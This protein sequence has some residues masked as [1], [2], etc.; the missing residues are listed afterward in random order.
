[1]NW[2]ITDDAN[3]KRGDW[4]YETWGDVLNSVS[5]F[6]IF[7]FFPN[8]GYSFVKIYAA[9]VDI[10]YQ[11]LKNGISYFGKMQAFFNSSP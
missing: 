11:T 7:N 9:F 2:S 5:C 4:K 3:Y 1:M 8:C 6:P 10:F